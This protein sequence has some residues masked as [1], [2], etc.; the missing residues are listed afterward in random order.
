[1]ELGFTMR[2]FDE[3]YSLPNA[4]H[5]RPTDFQNILLRDLTHAPYMHLRDLSHILALQ[6]IKCLNDF[7]FFCIF[8]C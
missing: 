4:K 2:K 1:M 8:Y 7:Y 3:F 5:S 6:N